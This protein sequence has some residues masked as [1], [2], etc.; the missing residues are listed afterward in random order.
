MVFGSNLDEDVLSLAGFTPEHLVQC[1]SKCVRL[2]QPGLD[3]PESLP[4]GNK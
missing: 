1:V 2:I 4:P 3:V